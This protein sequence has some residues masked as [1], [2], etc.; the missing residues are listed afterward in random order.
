MVRIAILGAGF[1]GEIHANAYRQINGAEVIA[2]VDKSKENGIKLARS[3][4][5]DYYGDLDELFKKADIDCVDIC[6]PTFLHHEMVLK[7]ASKN[8]HIFCEKPLTLTLEGAEE[9]LT[10][11]KN[12][13]IKSMVGHELRFWP[14]YIKAKEVLESGELGKPLHTFCQRLASFPDWHTNRWGSDEKLSGGAALD[15]HIHDLDYMLWLFGKPN[16]VKAQGVYNPEIIKH[17]GMVHIDTAIEFKNGVAGFAEGGW[18]FKGA[19]PFTM[20]LRILCEK[21]TIE[22]VFRAGK[23]IEERSQKSNVTVYKDDG[24]IKTLEVE[25]KD[26]FLIELTYF[27]DCIKNDRVVENATFKDGKDAVE[28]ALAAIKSAKEKTVI[29]F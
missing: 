2:V 4:D 3:I 10:A 23:N 12:K 11:V 19:F 27:I 5:A 24:S 22:W 21:G 1:I 20:A 13:N 28:L 8:K 14:E 7:V 17:G 29:K 6:V 15:L 16:M 25:Q 9:M 18:A 26:S